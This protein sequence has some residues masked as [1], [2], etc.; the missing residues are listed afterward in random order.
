MPNAMDIV[1]K[2]IIENEIKD[3]ELSTLVDKLLIMIFDYPALLTYFTN[4]NI[5]N[6]ILELEF[7]QLP[8]PIIDKIKKLIGDFDIE[9][10][11][12]YKNKQYFNCFR[13]DVN[14][15]KLKK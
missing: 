15:L 10:L 13:F 12:Y 9:V 1:S 5:N 14:N 6:N 11:S 4:V 3:N 8:I 7:N 2:F